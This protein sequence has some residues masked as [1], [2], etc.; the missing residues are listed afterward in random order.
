MRISISL[1]AV[2]LLAL[3]HSFSFAGFEDGL[4]L[5]M[6][7]DEGDGDTA[8]DFSGNG[9][10]GVIDNPDWVDG[11]HGKALQFDQVTTFVT[12][13]STDALNVNEMTFMAW[14]NAENWDAV[15]QIVGKSV[16]GGC[17]GRTQYGVFS[18]DGSFTLRFET[19]GGRS[20][21]VAALPPLDEWVH[22]AV[23]N[24]GSEGKIF[25]N[26]EEVGAG[27]VA[28]ALNANEDPWR[29]GQDCD[30]PDYIFAGI[31]DEVRLWNRA[32]DVDEIKDYMNKGA[33]EILAVA[34]ADKLST[35][36]GK[37]KAQD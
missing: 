22:I 7:L 24:D 16:H 37:V 21:I 3:V 6:P 27:P 15:R 20:D 10:D 18:A 17:A 9:H 8:G 12:V 5:Y 26:G 14:V 28:G 34:P 36:W 25:Y 1:F 4:V 29:I 31:I 30:R 13:E 11:K 32:M 2:L 33:K 19:A 35:A 23:T